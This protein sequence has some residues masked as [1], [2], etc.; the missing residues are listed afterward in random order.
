MKIIIQKYFKL[1]KG[2]II[3]KLKA[4]ILLAQLNKKKYYKALNFLNYYT[5]L[6]EIFN[7]DIEAI[8]N[9]VC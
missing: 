6:K 3:K 1:D 7:L 2:T 9:K 4:N 5:K 8:V